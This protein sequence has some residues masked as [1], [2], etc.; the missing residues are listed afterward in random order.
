VE[1]PERF[2]R[3]GA[4]RYRLTPQ[5][6]LERANRRMNLCMIGR[7]YRMF[8]GIANTM[9]Y[10]SRNTGKRSCMV[11]FGEKLEIFFEIYDINAI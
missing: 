2:Y 1:D 4:K 8:D 7:V 9:W 5:E 10:L 11:N 3:S 6:S